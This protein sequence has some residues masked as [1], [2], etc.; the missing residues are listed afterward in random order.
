ML[1]FQFYV[2]PGIFLI[3]IPH[4]KSPAREAWQFDINTNKVLLSKFKAEV[5]TWRDANALG[6][7]RDDQRLSRRGMRMQPPAHDSVGRLGQ[8]AAG[9][10][11]KRK[12]QLRDAPV[13]KHFNAIIA[14]M[15]QRH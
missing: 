3:H 15:N 9:V 11:P 6:F 14:G 13:P 5:T 8:G 7:C 1:G 12:T 4:P 2:P 10:A